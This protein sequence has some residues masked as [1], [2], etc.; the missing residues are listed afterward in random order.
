MRSC[1]GLSDYS[2]PGREDDERPR[3][4]QRGAGIVERF[5]DLRGK[6]GQFD[7]PATGRD[8]TSTAQ[9][10]PGKHLAV[11]SAHLLAIS[12]IM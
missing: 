4:P 10:Q 5:V 8:G 7:R 2:E 11:I 9:A 3:E 12:A 1:R 6:F